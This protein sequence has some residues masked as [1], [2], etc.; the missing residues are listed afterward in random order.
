MIQKQIIRL[1]EQQKD[2]IKISGLIENQSEINKEQTKTL[3]KLSE[4]MIIISEAIKEQRETLK[5]ID[6]KTEQHD[7]KL[8]A[9]D[10]KFIQQKLENEVKNSF[11]IVELIKKALPYLFVAGIVYL[12]SNANAIFSFLSK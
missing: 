10:I 9:L 3:T 11:N 12:L 6:E 5:K 4:T 8:E 2:F 1:E 7:E